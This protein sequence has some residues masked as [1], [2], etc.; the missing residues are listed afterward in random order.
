M[1]KEVKSYI[2]FTR[3]ERFGLIGLLSLLALLTLIR[4]SLPYFIQPKED[5]Q[6]NEALVAAWERF[7]EL[8]PENSSRIRKDYQDAGDENTTPLPDIINLNN[9]DSATLVRLKG[10]GPSTAHLIVERRK[11]EGPFNTIDQLN[12]LRHFPDSLMLLL[13]QHLVIGPVDTIRN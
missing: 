4:F 9:A 7:K 8:H 3:T 10:I 13:K 1:K 6:K 12:E 5:K 2:S 11:N